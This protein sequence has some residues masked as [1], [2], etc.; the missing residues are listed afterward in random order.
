MVCSPTVSAADEWT[1]RDEKWNDRVREI[2]GDLERSDISAS[3][4][5]KLEQEL[6]ELIDMR[7]RTRQEPLADQELVRIVKAHAPEKLV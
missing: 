3:R 7:L 2:D 6:E 1:M 5:L 4:R